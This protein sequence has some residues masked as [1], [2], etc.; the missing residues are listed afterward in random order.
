MIKVIIVTVEMMPMMDVSVSDKLVKS[1]YK[2]SG[3]FI[4]I[5]K[6]LKLLKTSCFKYIL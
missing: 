3:T 2:Q 4:I 6:S 5:F 1:E